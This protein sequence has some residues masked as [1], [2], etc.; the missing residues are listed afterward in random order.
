MAFSNEIVIN[1]HF[2]DLNP[3]L[4]GFENC[5]PSHSYGPAIR[6]C[7]LLHY[8]VSGSGSFTRDGKTHVLGA[9]D[10]F[11]IPPYT[12]IFYKADSE[13]PWTYIWIGFTSES[14]LPEV[15][16]S[17]VIHCAGAG[18][19]FEQ[20]KD[21]SNLEAGRS[22]FLSSR[23]WDL[24]SLLLEQGKSE[25][26]YIEKAIN[27]MRAEYMHP[28][29]VQTLANRIGL[30]RSYFTA[31]FKERTG[32]PPSQYLLRLRME[33]AAMLMVKR[34]ER[35]TTV[36]ASVGYPDPFHFSKT[37]KAYFGLSPREYI[38]KHQVL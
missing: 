25:V 23:L 8:V 22:A 15:F 4:F 13:T 11:V 32:F 16:T 26:D 31:L 18:E 9:G 1:Q 14:K 5:V 36:G 17:P 35:P 33:K 28:L 24:T 10:I 30:D 2:S 27:C 20:M 21:C 6:T 29:N 7:W 19:I 34:G 3:I 38:K 37:F 12:E